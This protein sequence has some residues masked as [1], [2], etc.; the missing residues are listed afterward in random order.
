M[1]TASAAAATNPDPEKARLLRDSSSHQHIP[2]PPFFPYLLLLP[3]PAP[4]HQATSTLLPH[5]ILKL[6][7]SP[8]LP[9]RRRPPNRRPPPNHPPLLHLPRPHHNH[10]RTPHQYHPRLGP[11]R[12]A[13]KRRG[14]G[15][16]EP[17]RVGGQEGPVL[18]AGE[19]GRPVG[20]CDG[21]RLRR[22]DEGGREEK[23]NH[24][25]RGEEGGMYIGRWNFGRE[26]GGVCCTS[27][28]RRY[29]YYYRITTIAS[30]FSVLLAFLDGVFPSS[31][32]LNRHS[33]GRQSKAGRGKKEAKRD[34]LTLHNHDV[35]NWSTTHVERPS[36]YDSAFPCLLLLPSLFL[37]MLSF[38]QKIRPI[39]KKKHTTAWIPAWSPTAVLASRSNDYVRQIGRDTQYSFASGR[40]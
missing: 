18:R 40:M 7:N 10:Y 17:K 19:R 28:C 11:Y 1:A 39:K 20:E 31:L 5:F 3:F 21:R 32:R 24:T 9:G 13:G 12:R 27:T 34:F 23:E 36:H 15:V 25:E 8:S 22:W 38:H 4:I 16:R 37:N 6:T 30:Y 33:V 14:Q 2:L 29:H 26:I 35:D